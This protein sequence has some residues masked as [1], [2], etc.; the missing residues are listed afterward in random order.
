[1]ASENFGTGKFGES[2]RGGKANRRVRK[3]EAI[4]TLTDTSA[5]VSW[6]KNK[7]AKF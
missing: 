3:N 2:G 5:A 7:K 6:Q 1:M 4:T